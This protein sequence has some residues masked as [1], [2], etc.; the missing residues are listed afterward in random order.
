[1]A[2]RDLHTSVQAHRSTLRKSEATT[3]PW[4]LLFPGQAAGQVIRSLAWMGPSGSEAALGKL[5]RKLP[6]SDLQAVAS[7]RAHL[8]TWLAS[9]VIALV[10]RA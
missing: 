5:I 2:G 3:P 4:Q 9:Q 10:L 1:M 7:A 8:P 6:A